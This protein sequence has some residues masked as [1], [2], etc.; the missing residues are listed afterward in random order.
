MR[1]KRE[2]T[3]EQWG[4]IKGIFPQYRTGRPPKNHRLMFEAIL[5]IARTGAP[6]RDLPDSYGPFE[7]V[8]SRFRKWQDSGLLEQLFHELSKDADKE[9]FSIDSTSVKAH[10]HSAGAKKGLKIQ[11]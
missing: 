5:W 9:T 1:N 6:W 2:L 4:Q 8:Y 7:T 11:K 10:Q 3:D